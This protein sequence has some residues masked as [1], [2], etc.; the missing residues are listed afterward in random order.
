M[1]N[2]FE[3]MNNGEYPFRYLANSTSQKVKK[4]NH[5]SRTGSPQSDW[6]GS[7]WGSPVVVLAPPRNNDPKLALNIDTYLTYVDK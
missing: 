4:F 5:H 7:I 2:N 6:T 1:T 3:C